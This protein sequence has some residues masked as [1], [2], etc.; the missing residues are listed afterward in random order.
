MRTPREIYAQYNI[1]PNLQLHQLRVAA[2]GK[3]V[4]DSFKQPVNANDVVLACL[5][6]DMGN[7]VKFKL[8]AFPEALQPE[9]LEYWEKQKAATIQKYGP[10]QH[11]VSETIA[12]E[13][14]LSDSVI[15]MIGNS[16]VSRIPE[17]LA[18]DSN[19]LKMLQYV[20]L[21]VAPA[22]IVSL[23]ERFEDFARRYADDKDAELFET[24]KELEGKIFANATIKPEDITDAAAAPIIEELW[25]YPVA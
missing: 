2:V 20:D 11:Q 17:I 4:C 13:I 23:E 14:G 3:L 8:D 19:E 9:G 12:Q 15:R 18:S 1:M 16:G 5:F 7:I 22:G 6:H 10:A 21:R 25:E 24:G